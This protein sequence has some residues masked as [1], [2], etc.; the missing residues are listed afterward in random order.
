MIKTEIDALVQDGK[1]SHKK[2]AAQKGAIQALSEQLSA[3]EKHRSA[4]EDKLD[5]TSEDEGRLEAMDDGGYDDDSAK[6]LERAVDW[7]QDKLEERATEAENA[8]SN[9]VSG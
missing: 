5:A 4:L 7:K 3:L 1:A 6:A 2:A 9:A 8:L